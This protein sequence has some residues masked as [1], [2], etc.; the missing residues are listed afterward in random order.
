MHERGRKIFLLQMMM[1]V[2]YGGGRDRGRERQRQVSYR[3]I[4]WTEQGIRRG[5]VAK[6]V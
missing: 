4:C 3:E 2:V 5:I 6:D 1:T